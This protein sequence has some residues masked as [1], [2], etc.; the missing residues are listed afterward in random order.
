MQNP[1]HK[2]GPLAW[3]AA[4][5]VAANLLMF[6]IIA[7][8][9][10]TI[11]TMKVE[12]FPEFTL[13]II[14]V[15]VPY[16]GASPADVE[17]GVVLRVEEAV[18]AVDGIKRLNATAA[19]GFGTVVVEVDEYA[20][21]KE[22]LDDVKAEVDRIITFPEET[23]KPI[24]AEV[25]TRY[26]V[27]TIV[28]Y[29]DVP[30]RTLKQLAD[31]LRDELT[32]MDNISQVDVAG[33][34]P[35]EISIEVSE[36]NLRRY[37]LTFDQVAAAV[38][39]S[40]LDIPAGSVKTSGGEVLVRTEGQMYYGPE[41]EKIIVITKNDG[42]NVRLG[43][44]AQV[45][46]DFED[47]DLYSR[48]DGK[49]AALVKVY[50]VGEQ[51]ALDVAD[52]VSRYVVQKKPFMPHGVSIDTWQDTS[53]MLRARMDLLKRNACLGLALVFICLTVFLNI[54]LAF[55]TT[56]GI[57]IS[58]LGAFW[59][60]PRFD[61]SLNMISLFA[62]IMSLGLVVDDAIVIGENIFSLRRQG[63]SRLDASIKG[64]REMVAPVTL[65]VLTTVF[66]FLPLA[67][68]TGIMG[69]IMRV[70]PVVVI[71]VLM[72]SL[73]EA[74]LILPAHLAGKGNFWKL[75]PFRL[76]D[77]IQGWTER[78]LEGFISNRFTNWVTRSVKYRYVTVAIALA[79]FLVTIG[80]ITG[81]YIKIVFFDPV[82]ADNMVATLVMP[83]G[84]PVDRTQQVV[85]RIE[86]TAEQIRREVDAERPGQPSI[87]K[88][89]ATTIG[90]QPVARGGGPVRG[91]GGVTDSHLAEV[92]I[93]LLG[94]EERQPISSTNLK[95][96][97]RDLVGEIPG[98]SS[99]TFFSEI[100][101]T[102]EPIN[103]ELSHQDF[104]FLLN[105]IEELK[106]LL[107][108]YSGVSD[109]ADSFEEGKAELKLDLKDSA[110]T[111][112]LTLADLARQVRQGFYGEE[113]QRI[114]RGRDDVR[115]MVRY[116]ENQRKSLADVENM[117][118][119]LPDGTEVPFKQVAQ[120]SYGRG[121]ATISRAERR[122]VVNVTADV[123]ET[124]ANA[125]EIN[126]DLA[127]RILPRLMQ[128][129][130][131]LQY[132]FAGEERERDESFGSLL[133][134]FPL[135]LLAIYALL[136]VQFRSYLQPLIVMSAIPFGIVGAVIGHI[137]MG[138]VFMT[139][140]NLSLLSMLGITALAGVVVNDSLILIDLINREREEG[141]AL[142]QIVRDC[143][144]RRFRPIMLTTLTT[145]FGLAPMMLERSLQARFLIPMAI[146]LAF[147]VMFATLI[148]LFLVPSLYMI[149]ED[150]KSRLLPTASQEQTLTE[151]Q[152]GLQT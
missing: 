73:V 64:A 19:E 71:S 110:R 141:V 55:W 40:S 143:A 21:T 72:V 66:A 28:I 4:N 13:D 140:F 112:G 100:M 109:I 43:D 23:E 51:G 25:T 76:V 124:V 26:E 20:D 50:R 102:G 59:L 12:F 3:F 78:R 15:S 94:A 80:W 139:T 151:T 145:F 60:L 75:A 54:R 128:E 88:H 77:K 32:A 22:V 114:Q 134:T 58:F 62:F 49:P 36:D 147:G 93:E 127:D 107:R 86:Q 41:F 152:P 37:G 34:R 92:N 115:V 48:F 103:V 129:Y 101:S 122:R 90:D 96:R 98:V 131:G 17:D 144:A 8:G 119:R 29:G 118:I 31:R 6:I 81:G 2:K 70:I 105:A 142:A 113:A 47:T 149:L 126:A 52:T 82:E 116:P 39:N 99:L 18:A 53:V 150:L 63:L 68:L 10:L 24:I 5:H 148:T 130:P 84:T 133:V 27:V 38:R 104:D 125:R 45:K 42:T 95:N 1:D 138:F 69:K 135:A 30:E 91:I 121:Y 79:I 132:R 89:M 7:A 136:A 97:W 117:R 9:L 120:V 16:L 85:R 137:L 14:T 33:V 123:D 111:L 87:I 74:L 11:F 83:L 46:D 108:E 146:S 67:F 35:Y 65:A 56:M 44:I 106:S 61:V 57:P